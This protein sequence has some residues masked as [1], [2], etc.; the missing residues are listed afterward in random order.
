MKSI[1]ICFV[2]LLTMAISSLADSSISIGSQNR[3]LW[4]SGNDDGND[5]I[6][7]PPDCI[8]LDTGVGVPVVSS[9]WEFYF[10]NKPSAQMNAVVSPSRWSSPVS[11]PTSTNNDGTY[12]YTDFNILSES[13]FIPL[14]IGDCNISNTI[15]YQANPNNISSTIYAKI[16]ILPP[17]RLYAT[18]NNSIADNDNTGQVVYQPVYIKLG[19][20]NHYY[21][22]AAID[23]TVTVNGY[24]LDLSS[25]NGISFNQIIDIPYSVMDQYNNGDIIYEYTWKVIANFYDGW[26]NKFT[27]TY[28]GYI[29]CIK[30]DYQSYRT[31]FSPY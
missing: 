17:T 24:N 23:A 11:I 21:N 4:L 28:N 14:S 22:N 19:D 13:A 2:S 7:C 25:W 18:S 8:V 31:G 10:G 9:D 26:D 27:Y 16:K 15:T 6:T 12:N 29:T 20:N 30:N 1:V 5:Y 3:I